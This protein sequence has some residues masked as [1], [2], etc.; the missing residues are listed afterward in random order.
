MVETNQFEIF[1]YEKWVQTVV[2]SLYSVNPVLCKSEKIRFCNSKLRLGIRSKQL[3]SKSQDIVIYGF[4][5]YN[6]PENSKMN[7]LCNKLFDYL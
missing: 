5:P 2:Q 7:I 4:N 3:Q 6:N 1:E